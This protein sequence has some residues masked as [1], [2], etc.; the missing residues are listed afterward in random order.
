MNEE[1][2]RLVKRTWKTFRNLEPSTVGDAFYTK[3][4]SDKPGL[5]KMFPTNMDEQYNKLMDMLSTI[6]ARLEKLETLSPDIA[7]LAKRHV[8]Y[9]VRPA[10]YKI[11]GN[12]L[13]WTLKQGLGNDW[14]VEVKNAWTDCYAILSGIMINGSAQHA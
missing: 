1:Q 5:K 7:E 8:K 6:V 10:H 2:I 9:G 14:T 3:L 13:L 12:A 11:V 4:F